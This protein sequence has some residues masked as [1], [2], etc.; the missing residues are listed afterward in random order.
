MMEKII[1]GSD[2]ETKALAA[3]LVSELKE[4]M[5]VA[6]KGDLGAGKTTFA[7]GMGEAL[8]V[9]RMTSPTYTLVRE[10]PL[11]EKKYGLQRLYHIDLYRLETA[12]EA[13][14]LGLNE[15]WF[16]PKHM[17]LIEWP[18][19]LEGYLPSPRVEIEFRKV[20]EDKREIEIK[21]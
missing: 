17:I 16:N 8:G 19:K 18:E 6:L 2:K 15:L 12:A 1:T 5:V 21:K 4:G 7:Q 13:F 11:D 14:G 3:K 10:Y 9:E 20:G